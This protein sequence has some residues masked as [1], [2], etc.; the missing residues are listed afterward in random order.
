LLDS[1]RKTKEETGPVVTDILREIPGFEWESVPTST[2]ISTSRKRTSKQYNLVVRV[3]PNAPNGQE[4][5]RVHVTLNDEEHCE[6][7]WS[8]RGML[9]RLEM[10]TAMRE[11]SHPADRLSCQRA[12][13]Q[14]D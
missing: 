7:V 8:T 1:S 11:S 13:R 3:P 5:G 2:S 14:E 10:I 12:L 6:R 4:E 9:D